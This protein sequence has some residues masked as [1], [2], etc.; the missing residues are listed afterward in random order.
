MAV[1]LSVCAIVKDEQENIRDMIRDAKRFADEIVIVD[2]G[3]TDETPKIAQELGAKVFNFKWNDNFSDARNYSIEKATGDWILWLDAD[4]R[5]PEEE[6]EKINELK[7]V[8]GNMRDTVFYFLVESTEA[9]GDTWHWF[10]LRLFPKIDGLRFEGRVHEQISFAAERLGLKHR[11]VNIKIIHTG[12]ADPEAMRKKM[13][14]NLRLLE[15]EERER[16]D[17][18]WTKKYLASSYSVLGDFERARRKFEEALQLCTSNFW[19]VDILISYA[20]LEA[21]LGNFNQSIELLK[22]AEN[23]I[24]TEGY[25]NLVK[26]EVFARA[27]RWDEALEEV[28]KA[29]SKGFTISLFPVSR[30]AVE[31]RTYMVKATSLFNLVM[32]SKATRYFKKLWERWE[33]IR[34]NLKLVSM[35]SEALMQV[36]EWGEAQKVIKEYLDLGGTPTA[37]LLSNY[38]LCLERQGKDDEAI[39]YYKKALQLEPENWEIAFNIAHLLYLKGRWVEALQNFTKYLQNVDFE[40]ESKEKILSALVVIANIYLQYGQVSQSIEP[41]D[42]SLKI[43]NAKADA[44]SVADISMAWKEVASKVQNTYLKTKA[45]ENA[46]LTLKFADDKDAQRIANQIKE[47]LDKLK[48]NLGLS[49]AVL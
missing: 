49:E 8:L 32:Y 22:E 10:Q 46:Y 45:L 39:E 36:G 3:S 44:K 21:R 47:E 4:D 30:E 1:K 25:I 42:I 16:P 18:W 19:K 31:R 13:M 6:A 35:Y 28:N 23:I 43:L 48:T 9:N 26:A 41:L 24:P 11:N 20:E 38:A 37:S 12:Y 27:E 2:T 33:E 17:A 15:L 7:K 5:V 29:I 14:R 34:K 40:K